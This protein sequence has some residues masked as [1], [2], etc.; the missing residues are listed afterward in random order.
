MSLNVLVGLHEDSLDIDVDI[1][2]LRVFFDE[3]DRPLRIRSTFGLQNCHD[4]FQWEPGTCV[5]CV[6]RVR[7]PRRP[8][9]TPPHHHRNHQKEVLH[10]RH[11]TPPPYACSRTELGG[12]LSYFLG[13]LRIMHFGN[14]FFSRLGLVLLILR[15]PEAR[16]VL[17]GILRRDTDN[18]VKI[19]RQLSGLRSFQGLEFLDEHVF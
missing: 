4:S 15:V 5:F 18:Q 7:G 2:L 3:S 14:A 12:G 19:N 6:V 10:A 8:R 11:P 16:G 17:F 1:N 9:S 13:M